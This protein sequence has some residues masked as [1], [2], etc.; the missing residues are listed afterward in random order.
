MEKRTFFSMLQITGATAGLVWVLLCFFPLTATGAQLNP[1]EISDLFHQGKE[2]F[3]QADTLAAQNPEKAR[4]LYLQ[5]AMRFE[6][7]I[8]KGGVYNGKLYYN[9]GNTYFRI[10]DIGRAILNYRRA[11]QHIPND[12]NLRQNLTFARNKRLDKIDDPQETKVFKT[13]FFW[14]YDLSIGT[15]VFI[16]A[17]MFLLIWIFCTL[18]LFYRK[19][20]INWNIF[21]FTVLAILFAGSLAVD[22]YYLH[23][24]RPGVVINPEV[25]ARKG[26][27]QTYEPSFTE[28]LHAG[29]EFTLIEDREDWHYIELQDS[30]KCWVPAA[31]V[32]LVR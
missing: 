31:D 18:R 8:S 23:T 16:F 13:L 5:A 25:I 11:L 7:I 15:R 21:T 27:S 28:P 20:Y 6:R 4:S 24:I 26:N 17:I 30:R 10:K 9:I 12:P 19:T 2:L 22:A 29:T 3:R 14:H 32:G 1:T